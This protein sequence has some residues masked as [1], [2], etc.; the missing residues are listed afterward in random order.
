MCNTT[1]KN[2]SVQTTSTTTNLA[3]LNAKLTIVYVEL[4]T[5]NELTPAGQEYCA[6]RLT[7]NLLM[8]PSVSN[9]G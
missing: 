6:S 7:V 1:K 4:H 8:L 3:P 2:Y 9:K 5:K